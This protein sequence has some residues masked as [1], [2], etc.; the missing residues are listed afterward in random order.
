MCTVNDQRIVVELLQSTDDQSL[1]GRLACVD[2]EGVSAMQF[3]HADLAYDWFEET[4]M[5]VKMPSGG[6]ASE[7][8]RYAD[9]VA[10]IT[11][12]TIAFDHRREP[13]DV[14]DLI[15]VMRFWGSPSP[16]IDQLV[17]TFRKRIENGLHVEALQ[18][19]IDLLERHF[20]DEPEIEGWEKEAPA[21]LAS[22][23]QI[24]QP[25]S[26]DRIREQR[27]VSALVTYFVKEVRGCVRQRLG[28]LNNIFVA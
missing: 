3:L 1:S 7:R 17:M 16:N 19:T 8:L 14:A 23:Y 6:I 21:M 10:F 9:P 22:F 24:G 13:K 28:H 12:K 27:E 25:E 26:D 20:C 11:L 4:E 15:H 5:K 18:K 2:D